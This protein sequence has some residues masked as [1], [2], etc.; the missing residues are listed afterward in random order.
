[1]CDGQAKVERYKKTNISLI[2]GVTSY[3]FIRF[4]LPL[5]SESIFTL[6]NNFRSSWFFQIPFFVFFSFALVIIFFSEYL[7][8]VEKKVRHEEMSSYKGIIKLQNF[9]AMSFVFISGYLVCLVFVR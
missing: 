6:K 4:A 1:M 2:L 5:S 9:V 7:K 3:L 8:R